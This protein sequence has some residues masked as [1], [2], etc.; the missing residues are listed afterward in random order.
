M[1]NECQLLLGI[2]RGIAVRNL[3][4]QT[5]GEPCPCEA[6]RPCPLA[7][8]PRGPLHLIPAQRAPNGAGAVA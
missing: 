8:A 2:D 3:I 6:G 5:T 7:A 4:R 1:L